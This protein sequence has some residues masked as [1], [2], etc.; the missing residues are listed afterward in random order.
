MASEREERQTCFGQGGNARRPDQ[1]RRRRVMLGLVF[2]A[3]LGMRAAHWSGQARHNPIFHAPRMDEG[4]H[5][6]WAH[7]RRFSWTRPWSFT[8]MTVLRFSRLKS[9]WRY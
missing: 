4:K 5:H 7:R 8:P 2:L 9:S 3:A 1:A 6:E